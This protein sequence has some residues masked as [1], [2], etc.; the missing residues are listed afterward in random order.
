MATKKAIVN[1]SGKLGELTSGDSLDIG[2]MA[3]N[4]FKGN[5]TSSAT[6]ALDLTPQQGNVMAND[7]GLAFLMAKV[8]YRI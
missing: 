8:K 1:K 2:F 6:T 5:N 3:A 7:F 4:T